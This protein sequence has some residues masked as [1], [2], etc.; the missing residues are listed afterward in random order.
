MS[1]PHAIKATTTCPSCMRPQSSD[2]TCENH[3]CAFCGRTY[4]WAEHLTLNLHRR[5]ATR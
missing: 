3:T 4:L 1:E 5:E 2:T